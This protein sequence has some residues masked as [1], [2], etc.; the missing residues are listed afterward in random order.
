MKEEFE[1]EMRKDISEETKMEKEMTEM[2]KQIENGEKAQ[3][4]DME[5]E[6]SQPDEVDDTS[7]FY[8][9]FVLRREGRR[10]LVWLYKTHRF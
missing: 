6:V 4:G 1:E 8:I 9:R 3:E 5:N 10:D 2:E 7:G